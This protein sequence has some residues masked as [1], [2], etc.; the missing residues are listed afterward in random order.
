MGKKLNQWVIN[1]LNRN[2]W[3]IRELSRRGEFSQSYISAVLSGKQDPG[4]K[5]YQGISKAFG[6]TLESVERL[7]NEGEVPE[8][9]LNDPALK[10]LLEL[11][12]SLPLS[13]LQEVL[14]YASYRL[15]KSKNLL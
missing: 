8:S 7:D 12:Q 11:A 9:R 2:G 5:S 15:K 6:I 1:Q 14:D 13:D 4:P 10:E 3:S